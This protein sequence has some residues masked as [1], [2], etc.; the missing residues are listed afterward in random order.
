MPRVYELVELEKRLQ[1]AKE[2]GRADFDRLLQLA[3]AAIAA[4]PVP[5]E[6]IEAIGE[7]MVEINGVQKRGLIKGK[8]DAGVEYSYPVVK[9]SDIFDAARAALG[10]RGVV[11]LAVPGGQPVNDGGEKWK[12]PFRFRVMHKSGGRLLIPENSQESIDIRVLDK[13]GDKALQKAFTVGLRVI[14]T[15]LLMISVTDDSATEEAQGK[16]TQREPSSAIGAKPQD[17]VGTLVDVKESAAGEWLV[18]FAAQTCLCR[19]SKLATS[20]R[21]MVQSGTT[22]NVKMRLVKQPDEEHPVI[23]ELLRTSEQISDRGKK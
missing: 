10:S 9:A 6:L 12:V 1:E 20:L 5:T 18:R 22:R 19:D 16:R 2:T 14:V 15:S 8:T 11:V 23:L 17:V 13:F 7:A 4:H 21:D 3:A